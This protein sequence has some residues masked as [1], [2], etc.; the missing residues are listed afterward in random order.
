MSV[1]ALDTG[2]SHIFGG[3]F[4]GD[5]LR[6]R[7]RKATDHRMSS[8]EL[9]IFLKS[10]LR[11]NSIDEK[12]VS[13]VSICSVVPELDHALRNCALKYFDV[14]PFFV[15]AGIKTG[16]K[17]KYRSPTEVG[18]DRIA[19]AIA[20]THLYPN[21]NLII[22]DFGT[23]T[24]FC[25]VTAD[26]EYLGGIIIPGLRISM[27]SLEKNTSKLPAVDIK[28]PESFVG[29]STIESIQ[30]GLYH[31]H[32]AMVQL[33]VNR[34]R[35]EHF[36]NQETR[37]VGTGGFGRLFEP[38]GVFDAFVPELALLGLNICQRANQEAQVSSLGM[39]RRKAS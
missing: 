13:S 8:D 16:L 17:I 23:A 4:E 28:V 14:E 39:Q 1:L 37:V 3:F 20:A 21:E 22:I 38:A 19:N 30:S 32:L 18:A 24:T 25:V 33:A 31:Q 35:K 5:Q 34:I 7:F 10:V 2:N 11:E 26:R 12:S 15:R 36:R 6:V 9:G 27:E 29:R